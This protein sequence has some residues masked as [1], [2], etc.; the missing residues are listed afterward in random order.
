PIR[1]VVLDETG[2]PLPFA[3]PAEAQVTGRWTGPAGRVVARGGP[4][5]ATDTPVRATTTASTA[6]APMTTAS[7]TEGA[8]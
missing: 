5:W 4:G 7:T 1:R 2:E 3:V 6:E 8:R